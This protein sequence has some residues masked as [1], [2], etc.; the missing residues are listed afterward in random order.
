MQSDNLTNSQATAEPCPVETFVGLFPCEDPRNGYLA[1]KRD[2]VWVS[3]C[4]WC[5]EPLPAS[6]MKPRRYCSEA[7]EKAFKRAGRFSKKIAHARKLVATDVE[8]GLHYFHKGLGTFVRD[9]AQSYR[10]KTL[11]LTFLP[12]ANQPDKLVKDFRTTHLMGGDGACPPVGSLAVTPRQVTHQVDELD[13]PSSSEPCPVLPEFLMTFT[14]DNP[15][16]FIGPL[17]KSGR[18]RKRGRA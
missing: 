9:G 18:S 8:F 5:E 6:K 16:L 11:G 2:G 12:A 4:P 3:L 1:V 13:R 14:P 17:L 15:P 7:H 10:H